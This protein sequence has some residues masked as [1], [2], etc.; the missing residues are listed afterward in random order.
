MITPNRER[1]D[2]TLLIFIIPI[3]IILMLVAGQAAIRLVPEWSVN[4]GMQSNL[5]PNNL[6]A[7]QSG[8]VQPVLPAILTPLSW[9]DTFLTPGADTGDNVVFPPFVV[10]EP[11]GTPVPTTPPPT[12]VTTQPPTIT[13]TVTRTPSVTV[14]PSAT[15]TKDPTDEPTS[16]STATST[17]T[18]TSTSTATSTATSTSTPAPT[19]TPEGI[20]SV[21]PPDLGVD[22]P[23]DGLPGD[24]LPGTYVVLDVSGNPIIV[25]SSPDGNYDLILYEATYTDPVTGDTVVL[26][27]QISILIS[28][29]GT[30]YY[31]VFN[32]GD[33]DPIT[34]DYIPDTN[35]NL[36]YTTLPAD[37]TGECDNREVPL[38]E[39]YVDP[40]TGVSTGILI[41][42]DTAPDNPPE[43]T[44]TY[45]IVV[46]PPGLDAA[47]VDSIVVD[48]VAL[49]AAPVAPVNNA[50]PAANEVAPAEEPSPPQENTD[51][52]AE[53]APEPPPANEPDPP[54]E[55]APEPPAEAPPSTP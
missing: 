48:E 32:W 4:A 14:S 39:F 34:G 27:D 49:P 54:A 55:Q 33:I 36:D 5:D 22:T 45:V 9:L 3:G 44:Y 30:N 51:P 50:A 42:V 40:V 35:T 29:D 37:C 41:D 26:M 1:R 19:T 21:V 24:L 17:A 43:G 2:W 10:L 28:Q 31:E 25:E 46:S 15:K 6:P 13:S 11:T 8:P 38:T 12:A 23:P 7:Q 18:S 47:Q 53:Q 20:P 52:P 16:T